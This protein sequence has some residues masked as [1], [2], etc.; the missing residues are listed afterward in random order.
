LFKHETVLKY[1]AV[2]ALQVK[3]DGVYV[4]C[5]LGGAGHSQL[6][7]SRLGSNGTL[8]GIDQDDHALRAAE[9]RLKDSPCR[10]FL[11]K[12]NFR[13]VIKVVN[14]LGF[15]Q[16]D[17][18][19]FD[20]GVSSPQLDQGDRGFS[21]HQDAPLDMRM[22]QEQEY[23]AFHVVNYAEEKELSRILFEYGEE[24]FS[25]RIARE[26]VE[27]RKK[28]L[29]KTT[30]ELVDVIKRAIPAAARRS[31]PHPARRTFQAIRIE[32]NDE[33]GAFRDALAQAVQLLKPGGRVSV[34]TFH[35]LED[36]ICKKFF[37]DCAKGCI[38]PP[39]FPICTCLQK[40]TLKMITKKPVV[41]S[42]EEIEKNARA[43]SAKL[44]VAEKC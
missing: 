8:I 23:S 37:M 5:T 4:D 32:V 20:L 18:V 10:L 13:R 33:L 6:I 43:R 34:I 16:V 24:R 36:R 31:G 19:L 27:T 3:E 28:G 15:T 26:I 22:D 21:Y 29:I 11:V 14:K 41:P 30:F 2:D 39:H 44:R 42:K 35:S 38:C 1:E 12:S 25:R 17:G 40:P 7:V 9:E